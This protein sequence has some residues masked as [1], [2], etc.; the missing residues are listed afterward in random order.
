[1]YSS[2][3][4]AFDKNVALLEELCRK[5]PAFA[6][7]VQ[8]FEVMTPTQPVLPPNT[9]TLV[10]LLSFVFLVLT[11]GVCECLITQAC[12]KII[13]KKWCLVRIQFD[14]RTKK[15][16]SAFR[17]GDYVFI[18]VCLTFLYRAVRAVPISP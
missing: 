5:S 18:A 12:V 11:V 10:A 4:C 8:E 6:K 13:A 2:Y 17:A 15:E 9:Q 1:M 14:A 16:T 7:V 3:I